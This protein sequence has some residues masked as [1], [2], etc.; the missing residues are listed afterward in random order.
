MAGVPIIETARF[1]LRG[2]ERRDFEAYAAMWAD[3]RTTRYIGS[4]PRDRT[5][6]WAKFTSMAGLWPLMGYGYWVFAE[7]DSDAFAGCGGLCWFDRGVDALVGF[8]EAGWAVAPD[9]WGRGAASEIMAAALDWSDSVLGAAEVRC[10]I[11]PGNG[12]SERV[13]AKLGFAAIGSSDALGDPV[14]VYSRM[15]AGG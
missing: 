7:R 10:I 12:A 8:P 3:A 15:R 1:R 6:S 9:H 14:T 5:T 4:G 2:A 11:N 13:A